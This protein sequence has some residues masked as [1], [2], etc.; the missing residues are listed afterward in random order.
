MNSIKYI[1]VDVHSSRCSL[2]VMDSQGVE[3]DNTTIV[4]NGR[5]LIDYI[6]SIGDN[7]VVALE[8]CDLS[9][10][11]FDILHH[12]VR[13]VVVCNPAANAEYK[14]AKTDKLD[15]RHLAHLLR[16]GY[17]LPVFHDGSDR[18]KFR[19][20]VSAYEDIVGEIVRARNRLRALRRRAQPSAQKNFLNHAEF[21]KERSLEHLQQLLQSQENYKIKLQDCLKHFPETK[22]LLSIPG[23]GPIQTARII[24]QVVDPRRFKN[25]YKFFAYCGL[26]RH[27]RISNRR[28]YGASRIFGNR[29]LKCVFKMA[30]HSALKGDNALR[31]YYE[32][33]RNKGNNHDEARNAVARKIA[34]LTLTLWK[35]K[36][37]FNEKKFLQ[38]LPGKE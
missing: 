5:L 7:T 21:I 17:L 37:Y 10:W 9:G 1:G 11:L 19:L 2:S 20:L 6:K 15:A 28:F 32:S 16:G 27:P 36:Q 13:Q 34:T 8:E 23:I 26:V 35:N 30:A 25:K 31:T 14:R 12:H 18:E 3:I 24:A 33:L 29:I 22:Y 4:T 38:S